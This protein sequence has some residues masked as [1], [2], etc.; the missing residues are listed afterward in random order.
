[1]LILLFFQHSAPY[2]LIDCWYFDIPDNTVWY[3]VGT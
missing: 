3:D 1:L 2:L